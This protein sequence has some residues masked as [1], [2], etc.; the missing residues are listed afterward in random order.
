MKI[1][2]LPPRD[3][4]F[5]ND[6]WNIQIQVKPKLVDDLHVRLARPLQAISKEASWRATYLAMCRSPI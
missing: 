3:R 5:S 6:Q 2:S 1:N 4:R